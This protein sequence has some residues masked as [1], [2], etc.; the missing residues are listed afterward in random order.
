MTVGY[1]IYKQLMFYGRAGTSA[2]AGLILLVATVGLTILQFRRFS[3][4]VEY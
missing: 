2:A 3:Q 4:V 1:Y